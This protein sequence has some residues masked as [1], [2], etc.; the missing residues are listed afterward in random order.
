MELDERGLGRGTAAEGEAGGRRRGSR[1]RALFV[2]VYPRV[3]IDI[4]DIDAK[5]TRLLDYHL[6]EIRLL[7][8]ESQI[9]PHFRQ[10]LLGGKAALHL[11]LREEHVDLVH[12]GGP[13]QLEDFLCCHRLHQFLDR[14]EFLGED[15]VHRKAVL[16]VG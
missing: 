8:I 10:S 16:D 15:Y 11:K 6:V 14:H 4:A 5:G 13:L 2:D 12:E 9:Y 7:A 3:V 1:F